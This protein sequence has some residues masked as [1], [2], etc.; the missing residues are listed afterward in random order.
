MRSLRRVRNV[1]A[2]AVA[3]AH[4]V[5]SEEVRRELDAWRAVLPRLP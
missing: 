5:R 1:V 3:I 4:R 2:P